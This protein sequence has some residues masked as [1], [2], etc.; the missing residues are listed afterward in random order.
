ME[1]DPKRLYQ[2]ITGEI[3]YIASSLQLI[4]CVK[5]W[6]YNRPP[7]EDRVKDL[8]Q[9]IKT[10]NKI[11]GI[12]CI[13]RLDNELICYDGQTRLE[14]LKY[15]PDNIEVLFEYVHV[16]SH[17]ELFEKFKIVNKCV[18]VP[19]IY[20][21][22][23]HEN[24]TILIKSEWILKQLKNT[25]NG[26]QSIKNNPQRPNY[27]RDNLHEYLSDFF[28]NKGKLLTKEELWNK[29]LIY[30]EKEKKENL[31]DIPDIIKNKC[32]KTGCYLFARRK[33]NEF[34]RYI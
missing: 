17:E 4:K 33:Y 14:A 19:D 5:K 15:I 10:N 2:K 30:N 29:M 23:E 18:P 8:I 32:V 31:N 21:E 27:N 13:A 20:L 26:I 16:N 28:K 24:E 25:F 11:D 1:I 34:L 6:K 12:I 9:Y 22:N 7:D 3:I